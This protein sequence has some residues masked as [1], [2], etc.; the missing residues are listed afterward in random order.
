MFRDSINP[1]FMTL[2]FTFWVEDGEWTTDHGKMKGT[3]R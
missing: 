3:I 1:S 2:R